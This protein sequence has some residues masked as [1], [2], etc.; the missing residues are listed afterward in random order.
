MKEVTLRGGEKCD[1]E[2]GRDDVEGQGGV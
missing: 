2:G 1:E